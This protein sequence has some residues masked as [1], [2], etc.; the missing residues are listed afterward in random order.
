MK[1]FELNQEQISELLDKLYGFA[2]EGIPGT[3]SCVTL[4][5]DYLER[6]YEPEKA[7]QRL[8]NN[9]IAKCSTSGFVT[10][11]GG[12]ITLPVAIPANVSSVI[13]MQMRMIAA[14]AAIAGY[15][16]Q[17]DEVQT[18]V[19]ICLVNSSIRDVCKS[20]G[21][22]ITNKVTMNM[23]KK[24]PGSVLAKI[25]K[26]VGFRLVT[27]FGTTGVINLGKL[28]PVVGGFVGAGVDFAGTK[29]IAN[30]AYKT[31]IEH[32]LD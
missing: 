30:R 32:D 1:K 31:F 15:N 27:K 16:V 29:V 18:L 21:V 7:A 22:Q 6:F 9:Q 17:S 20:A 14:L 28:V 4:A 11:L 2:I 23:L 3:K 10:S 26:A 5:N 19:Y 13:Y 12:L 8:I 25:N 24:L